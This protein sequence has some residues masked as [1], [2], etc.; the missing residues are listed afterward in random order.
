MSRFI[1]IVV[2]KCTGRT[3]N[4]HPVIGGDVVASSWYI[5]I[6]WFVLFFQYV[7]SLI[8]YFYGILEQYQTTP[9][10]NNYRK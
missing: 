10:F 2:L 5:Y 8:L 6:L 4:T 1:Y 9:F 7:C 3:C